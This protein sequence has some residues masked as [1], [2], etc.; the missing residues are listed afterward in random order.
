MKAEVPSRKSSL[1]THE[2][3]HFLGAMPDSLSHDQMVDLDKTFKLTQSRNSEIQEAWYLLSINQGYG[4]E[5]LSSI[6]QFLVNVGRRKFLTP[7]YTA[8]VKNGMKEEAK[9]IF[10]EAK[11]NY[12]SVSYNTI[13]ALLDKEG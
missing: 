13:K 7:L 6:R 1:S 8:M 10:E 9:A 3:L 12:H 2:W 4:K 11:A 5:I